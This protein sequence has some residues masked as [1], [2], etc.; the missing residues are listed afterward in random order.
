M[1]RSASFNASECAFERVAMRGD[2]LALA[3]EFEEHFGL[4]AQDVGLDRLLDE[5]HRARLVAAKSALPVGVSRRHE[6]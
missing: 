2:L 6:T 4:A 3:I 1:R 5:I